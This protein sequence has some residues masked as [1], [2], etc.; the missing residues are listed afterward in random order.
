MV[1]LVSDA[2]LDQPEYRVIEVKN[3][4]RNQK[5]MTLVAA[6]V[7]LVCGMEQVLRSLRGWDEYVFK[8]AIP[9]EITHALQTSSQKSWSSK[10]RAA[11]PNGKGR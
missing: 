4:S 2:L 9:T 7:C 11:K 6:D 10:Q 1:S 3:F 5:N 8:R